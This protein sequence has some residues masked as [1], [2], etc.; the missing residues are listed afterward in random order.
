MLQ[1]LVMVPILAIG[2]FRRQK[3]M[4]GVRRDRGETMVLVY[5]LGVVSYYGIITSKRIRGPAITAV[6]ALAAM[7]H[8]TSHRLRRAAVRALGGMR[9]CKQAKNSE[10][11][12]DRESTSD[13]SNDST[14]SVGE[15]AGHLEGDCVPTGHF[16]HGVS[17]LGA[18]M[19]FIHSCLQLPQ[20]ASGLLLQLYEVASLPASSPSIP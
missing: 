1:S 9:L 3:N 20:I 12:Y 2:D 17:L 5:R 16:E 13:S 4:G 6:Q 10:I 8:G 15:D 18:S 11:E 7:A 14:S 19:H